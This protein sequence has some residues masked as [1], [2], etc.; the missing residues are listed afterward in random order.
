[1]AF[2]NKEQALGLPKGTVRAILAVGIIGVFCYAVITTKDSI[3]ITGADLKGLVSMIVT[4]YFAFKMHQNKKWRLTKEIIVF[5]L[6]FV[7]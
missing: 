7:G 3:K 6:H 2:W 4:F 5:C 1:M